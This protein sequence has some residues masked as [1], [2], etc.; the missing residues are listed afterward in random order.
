MIISAMSAAVNRTV[1]DTPRR[2]C[3]RHTA[4]ERSRRRGRT[5]LFFLDP[6]SRG[7]GLTDSH[8]LAGGVR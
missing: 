2:V 6:Q 7:L 8:V 4:A 3:L 5:R 1:G